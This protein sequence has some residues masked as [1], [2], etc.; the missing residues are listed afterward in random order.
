MSSGLVK[1][2][3][4]CAFPAKFPCLPRF[5]TVHLE[6]ACWISNLCMSREYK[7][8]RTVLHKRIHSCLVLAFVLQVHGSR[9]FLKGNERL[10]DSL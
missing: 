2:L 1:S 8:N 6:A 7:L 5:A 4:T 10:P 3:L 9:L